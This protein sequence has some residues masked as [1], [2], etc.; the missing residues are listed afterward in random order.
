[1]DVARGHLAALKKFK[2]K[3]AIHIQQ[4]QNC[5]ASEEGGFWVYNLGTGQ[6]YSVL[7]VLASFK[8]ACGTEIQ[9]AYEPRRK[10]D[11]PVLVADP[12]LANT[13][14][15]WKAEKNMEAM[16]ADFWRWQKMNPFGYK[17]NPVLEG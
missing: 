3:N 13:E 9:Y 10:G 5:S 11:V 7:Q 16:C 14:L 4:Q 15:G 6:G 8:L 1:M 12:T 2:S 17:K